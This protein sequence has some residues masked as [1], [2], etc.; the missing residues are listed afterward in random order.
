[1]HHGALLDFLFGVALL[2]R[3]VGGLDLDLRLR[4]RPARGPLAISRQ[5]CSMVALV[6]YALNTM[7]NITHVVECFPM[8]TQHG[9]VSAV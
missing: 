9:F 6:A 7:Y 3:R 8:A 5:T 2:L 1:M 4:A